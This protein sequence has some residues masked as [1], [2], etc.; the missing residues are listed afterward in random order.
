M[1][2]WREGGAECGEDREGS[3]VR[4]GSKRVRRWANSPFH[5]EPRIPGSCQVT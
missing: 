4:E 5:I 3:G 2:T 1:N